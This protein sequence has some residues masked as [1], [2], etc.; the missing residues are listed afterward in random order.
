MGLGFRDYREPGGNIAA[1]YSPEAL[2]DVHRLKSATSSGYRQ[3]VP[4][5]A[6]RRIQRLKSVRSP[7]TL[8][9][10]QIANSGVKVTDPA[11]RADA[12]WWHTWRCHP[13]LVILHFVPNDKGELVLQV[14]G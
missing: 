5:P 8:E 2:P 12:K 11:G 10:Y 14:V 1:I 9:P 7:Q 6:N 4:Q 13:S 3:G